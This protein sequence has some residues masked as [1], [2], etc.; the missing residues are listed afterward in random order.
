MLQG[1]LNVRSLV[2]VSSHS[3]SLEAGGLARITERFCH[4]RVMVLSVIRNDF[5]L[6][7]T[8]ER[9]QDTF[10]VKFCGDFSERKQYFLG[11]S[12]LLGLYYG[13]LLH[14]KK[15]SIDGSGNQS[16]ALPQRLLCEGHYLH[17]FWSVNNTVCLTDSLYWNPFRSMHFYGNKNDKYCDVKQRWKNQPHL[18]LLLSSDKSFK[19]DVSSLTSD[20]SLLIEL[21]RLL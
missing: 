13:D 11:I 6:H 20:Y 12:V 16:I 2:K 15:T 17:W 3:S 5:L 21:W 8:R 18:F 14:E 1:N 4:L 7:F 19:G 10:T 9:K